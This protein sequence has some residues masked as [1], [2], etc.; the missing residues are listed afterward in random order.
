MCT[1]ERA[2]HSQ[3][4]HFPVAF[5]LAEIVVMYSGQNVQYAGLGRGEK[6]AAANRGVRFKCVVEVGVKTSTFSSVGCKSSLVDFLSFTHLPA[7]TYMAELKY[8][9]W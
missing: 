6:P 8:L 1:S 5:L 2:C 4:C 9:H 7:M 3:S